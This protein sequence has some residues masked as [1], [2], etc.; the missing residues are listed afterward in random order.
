[1]GNTVQKLRSIAWRIARRFPPGRRL[2][3]Y[4]GRRRAQA[5]QFQD[6]YSK[7]M[8]SP[9]TPFNIFKG[10]WNSAIPGFPTGESALFD[11]FRVRW[12]EGQYGSFAGKR[13]LELGPLE[14]GHTYMLEQAKAQ[15]TAIEANQRAFLKC[16]IVKN[17]FQLKSEFLYG[18]FRPYL[19]AAK[20]G[21]FDFVLA[22]G[23]LYHMTEPVKLLH[24]IARVTDAF[25]LW[26]H[27]YDVDRFKTDVRFSSQPV[28]QTVDGTAVE[29]Y[30]QHYLSSLTSSRFIGGSE[31]TSCWLTK[32]AL[33]G[34]LKQ[35]G[36]QVEVGDDNPDHPHGPCILLFA[37]RQ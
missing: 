19:A 10:T 24:D 35:L 36:F 37:R 29:V 16:L 25:G 9:V 11:D 33:L 27:Y 3:Q 5:P 6:L 1:M 8:P 17:A 12:L 30:Q 7:E 18:D 31:P 14:G 20:A 28:L 22:I 23:V 26:T 32:A 15:V 21:E 34:Y 13:V 2:I 4:A